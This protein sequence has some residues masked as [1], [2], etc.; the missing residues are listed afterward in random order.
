MVA[1]PGQAM[2][3]VLQGRQY[4]ELWLVYAVKGEKGEELAGMVRTGR[5]TPRCGSIRTLF[6]DPKFRKLGIGEALVRAAVKQL[7]EEPHLLKEDLTPLTSQPLAIGD[8]TLFV[9]IENAGAMRLYRRLGFGLDEESEWMEEDGKSWE[10]WL[11]MGYAGQER[12]GW[13]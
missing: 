7:M 12:M 8:V 4:K 3:V 5:L 6:V 2:S 10:P 11:E 13:P 9:E 1:P